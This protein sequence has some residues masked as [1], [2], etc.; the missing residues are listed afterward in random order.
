MVWSASTCEKDSWFGLNSGHREGSVSAVFKGTGNATLN[1]GNCWSSLSHKVRVYING[2]V[3]A[4][5]TGNEFTKEVNFAFSKGDTMK[6][7]E[8][9]A[10]IKLNSF[11]ITRN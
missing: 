9:G 2:I 4:T 6:I 10:I 5:A 8:D 11:T 1:F 7:E 3:I